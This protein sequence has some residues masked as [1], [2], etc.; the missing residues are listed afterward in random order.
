MK[1][2]EVMKMV[3]KNNNKTELKHSLLRFKPHGFWIALLFEEDI[4]NIQNK[5][6]F[7]NFTCDKI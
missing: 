6:K 4:I 7:E 2:F 5:K 1:G 3:E